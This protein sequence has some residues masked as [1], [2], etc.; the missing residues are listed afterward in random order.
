MVCSVITAEITEN[1]TLRS[2]SENFSPRH[3][4]TKSPRD[5][6]DITG[7]GQHRC[8]DRA[9]LVAP[10]GRRR[11]LVVMATEPVAHRFTVAE[12]EAMGRA[13][14]LPEEARLELL[15]GEIVEMTPIG[16][17]HASIVNRLNRILVSGLGD[18]AVVAV[19]NPVVLSDLSMPQPD[20]AV[21]R[22]RGDF[23]ASA[24]PRPDDVL[25][26]I[27]VADSTVSWDSRVKRPLYAAAGV[28]EVWIVDVADRV[29]EVAL[30][31]AGD[32]YQ[33]VVQAGVGMT[34][35]SAAFPDLGIP[36]AELFA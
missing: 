18:R 28:P 27:E 9:V 29:V 8:R 3:A 6:R 25:L 35:A 7:A 5:H 36:V 21:L 13:G 1:V 16:S 19:Q 23:Y 17:P 4:A 15:R 24:H 30:Q 10:A 31:P 22:A 33:R 20:L 26:V 11:S 12:Y 14:V 2:P 34:I 32:L